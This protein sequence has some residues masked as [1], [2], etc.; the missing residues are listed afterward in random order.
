PL[1]HSQGFSPILCP[2][3]GLDELIALARE[4]QRQPRPPH[5]GSAAVCSRLLRDEDFSP[6]SIF[7]RFA[8]NE[9]VVRT[10]A[11]YMGVAPYLTH[12]DL[13]ESNPGTAPPSD[14]QLWHTDRTDHAVVKLVVYVSDV[15]QEHGPLCA[16]PRPESRKVPRVHAHYVPDDRLASYVDRSR[17]VPLLGPAGSTFLVDTH[18]CLHMGSR[19]QSQRLAYF[20]FYETGFGTDRVWAIDKLRLQALSESQRMLLTIGNWSYFGRPR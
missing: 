7:V 6:H 18:N 14:S 15:T 4:R 13:V 5:A 17:M 9:R 19:A 11:K 1:L 3:P 16:Y 12:L 8:L 10:V 2:L 20:A